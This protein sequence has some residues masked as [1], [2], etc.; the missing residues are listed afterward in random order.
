[1][2]N[3]TPVLADSIILMKRETKSSDETEKN[4]HRTFQ[5]NIF[6]N[7]LENVSFTIT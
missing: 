3:I 5:K 1:M 4:V 6:L 7:L 2:I